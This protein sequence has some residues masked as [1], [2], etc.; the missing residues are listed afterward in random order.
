M[1]YW[2][3]VGRPPSRVGPDAAVGDSVTFSDAQDLDSATSIDQ[4]VGAM[5]DPNPAIR[6]SAREVAI[7]LDGLLAARM[8]TAVGS[9]TMEHP[10]SGSSQGPAAEVVVG[11]N[12]DLSGRDRLGR[13]ALRERLGQGGMGTVYRGEDLADGSSVAG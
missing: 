11:P 6:P 9:E 8:A 5:L 13:Y 10:N 2:L 3:L 7:R 1:L 4:L 12:G